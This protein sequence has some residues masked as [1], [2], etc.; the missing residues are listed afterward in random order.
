MSLA[1]NTALNLA[2]Q[3]LPLLVAIVAFPALWEALG[4]EQFGMLLLIWSVVG[5]FSLF[6]LGLGRG[7]TRIVA[8]VARQ[9]SRFAMCD[10]VGVG[11][12]V[13]AAIGVLAVLLTVS[14]VP[15]AAPILVQDDAIA[16]QRVVVLLT[17][18][19]YAIPLTVVGL[20]F[21]ASLEGLQRFDLTVAVRV[22]FA[23]FLLGSPY[24]V[25]RAGGELEHVVLT[26]L[27]GILAVAAAYGLLLL[28]ALQPFRPCS[29]GLHRMEILGSL[30]RYSG[31]VS[32]S[33]LTAPLLYYVDRFV[34]SALL[35]VGVMSYY[36]TPYEV[37]TKAL[38]GASAVSGAFFPLL[39]GFPKDQIARA[40]PLV[41]TG[42]KL[43]FLLTLPVA[44]VCCIWA[45]SALTL[46]MGAEVAEQGSRVL[47]ILACGV[48]LNAAAYM[49]F[50]FLQAAG[51]PDLT[52][53]LHMIELPIYAVVLAIAIPRVGIVGAAWVWA[54]RAL[55]ELIV[56]ALMTSRIAGV[57]QARC[58]L[59][60]FIGCTAVLV[61]ISFSDLLP[62]PRTR[63]VLVA[64]SSALLLTFCWFRLL[65][66]A[67]R[68]RLRA[69]V[70][71]RRA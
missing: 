42:S 16:P 28:R 14:L 62:D 34:I 65:E 47:Q 70:V 36:V 58:D 59:A 4:R 17:L 22:P 3:V 68:D 44:L 11:L 69:F 66:Q 35:G 60:S 54:A 6:D 25:V 26:L 57:S 52:A 53:R 49:P 31:W 29:T 27:V 10:V 5:Y 46:W 61:G 45:E 9:D 13:M 41:R 7:L 18:T 51:R 67:E 19:C 50:T 48:L 56:F 43:N 30:A 12:V 37:I 23:V 1:R 21:R 40:I 8:Q 20:C 38:I 71:H 24:L 2:G 33:N 55:I 63:A 32:V 64:A 15:W 39:A